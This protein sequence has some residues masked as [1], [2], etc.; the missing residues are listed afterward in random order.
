M[1][2]PPRLGALV[3]PRGTQLRVWAPAAGQVTLEIE[4]GRSVP[5][6]TQD[7]EYHEVFVEDAGPGSRYR[8]RLDDGDPL[9]DPASRFQPDG[10]HGPS[11]VV[12]PSFEWT[13]QQWTPPPLADL[14]F[15]ELHVGTFSPA[16]TFAGVRERLQ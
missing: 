12:D 8:L 6:A 15:Y 9:P 2:I 1:H 5:L 11:E 10:V 3:T 7:R 13:D 4:G 16:G 14:V